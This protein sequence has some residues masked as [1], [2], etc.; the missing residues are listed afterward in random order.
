MSIGRSIYNKWY[1]TWFNGDFNNY[2]QGDHEP[3]ENKLLV[4]FVEWNLMFNG[5]MF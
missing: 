3:Q 5:F 1:L 4:W 2:M